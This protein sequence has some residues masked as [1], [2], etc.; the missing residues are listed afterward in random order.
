MYQIIPPM[1]PFKK[2]EI[3]AQDMLNNTVADLIRDRLLSNQTNEIID[4]IQEKIVFDPIAYADPTPR[5]RRF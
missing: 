4:K 3:L 2:Q 1:D 5:L